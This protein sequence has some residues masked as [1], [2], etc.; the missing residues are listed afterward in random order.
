[1]LLMLIRAI[2]I[3]FTIA[4]STNI[5]A[6]YL[7]GN[8]L[9]ERCATKD[10]DQDYYLNISSCRGYITGVAD[11]YDGYS[12]CI[13]N[14]VN[15]GQNSDIVTK[16]LHDHPEDRHQDAHVLTAYA[17]SIAFPCKKQK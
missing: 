11:A 2:T 9:Y 16:Y 13:P 6:G 1:M 10:G 8:M 15:I 14:Q 5:Y 17:L 7:N 12:F 3:I 4:F